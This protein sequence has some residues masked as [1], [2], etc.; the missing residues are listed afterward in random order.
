MPWTSSL[1]KY[2]KS[3]TASSLKPIRPETPGGPGTSW[4]HAASSEPWQPNTWPASLIGQRSRRCSL[5]VNCVLTKSIDKTTS[6]P[7]LFF[8]HQDQIKFLLSS[9][10]GLHP[11]LFHEYVESTVPYYYLPIQK[12]KFALGCR[13]PLCRWMPEHLEILREIPIDDFMGWGP[14][15]LLPE[16]ARRMEGILMTCNLIIRLSTDRSEE[17]TSELQ[18][19]D[20][21]VCR[22]L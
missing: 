18:S 1:Q 13:N 2:G 3:F 11:N 7:Y 20:H 5:N 4:P 19:P 6:A 12:K 17:H 15:F 22:L 9:F 21:L 8:L 14:A 10:T 16:Y